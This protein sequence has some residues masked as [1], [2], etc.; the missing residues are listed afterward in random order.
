MYRTKSSF[1]NK[2]TLIRL[3]L[4]QKLQEDPTK[5][6]QRLQHQQQQSC[7]LHGERTLPGSGKKCQRIL[8][9][10]HQR[11]QQILQIRSAATSAA[12]AAAAYVH[13]H[14]FMN[15]RSYRGC[16]HQHRLQSR[17]EEELV[18]VRDSD[19]YR[20]G[21]GRRGMAGQ[22]GGVSGAAGLLGGGGAE[23]GDAPAAARP[24]LALPGQNRP[25]RQRRERRRRGR[26]G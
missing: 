26:G 15:Q 19:W 8:F 5:W 20:R 13:H 21:R 25:H 6:P 14:Q 18:L 7:N 3:S 23:G 22:V 4:P 10:T 17:R 24:L 2:R 9:I 1:K 16:R 11:V 12:V